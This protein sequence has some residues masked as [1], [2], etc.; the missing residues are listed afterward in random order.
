MCERKIVAVRHVRQRTT[1]DRRRDR[2]A[3][4]PE[5]HGLRRE[6]LARER[7]L[8][9]AQHARAL[10]RGQARE[11][12]PDQCVGRAVERPARRARRERNG[13]AAVDLKQQVGARKRER[14]QA[15]VLAA[16]APLGG[17]VADWP[18]PGLAHILFCHSP[19]P[20]KP[21]ICDKRARSR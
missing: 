21:P 13:G 9:F 17:R 20:E 18:A 12:D 19:A 10:G 11:L 7:F 14:E 16:G 15:R 5:E 8:K 1:G 4:A 2:L 3:A 6:A